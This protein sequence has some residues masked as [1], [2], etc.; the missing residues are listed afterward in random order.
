MS[1]VTTKLEGP[2][3]REITLGASPYTLTIDPDG[4][5]LVPKGKRK[6]FELAW[7]DLV[8]GDAAMASAL[9]ASLAGISER[10]TA[11]AAAARRK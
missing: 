4:L 9:N 3:K 11:R 7:K 5:H 8:N 10:S 1:N 6:G 2:L